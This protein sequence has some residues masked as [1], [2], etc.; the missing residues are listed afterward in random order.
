MQGTLKLTHASFEEAAGVLEERTDVPL[1]LV[2]KKELLASVPKQATRFLSLL[3]AALEGE[4]HD[5][6]KVYSIKTSWS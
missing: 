6:R 3:L 2:T 5:G 4:W 1:Y